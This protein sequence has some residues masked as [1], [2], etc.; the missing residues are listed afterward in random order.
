M[1]IIE[2]SINPQLSTKSNGGR[3]RIKRK[4][5]VRYHSFRRREGEE[6]LTST[7]AVANL[8]FSYSLDK[9]YFFRRRLAARREI[10]NEGQNKCPWQLARFGQLFS[11]I[12]SLAR[13]FHRAPGV[14]GN[15]RGIRFRG[16]PCRDF[17]HPFYEIITNLWI[18]AVPC[19]S[20]ACTRFGRSVNK[21]F[22]D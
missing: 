10:E 19:A 5:R 21:I 1:R 9:S 16:P 14:L 7:R 22:C 13:S 3:A 17:Q 20:L 8:S 6:M 11:A 18:W 15:G 4:T 12:R 2:K